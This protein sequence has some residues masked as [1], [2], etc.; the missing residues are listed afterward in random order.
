MSWFELLEAIPQSGKVTKVSPDGK[1]IS[2]QTAPGQSLELDLDKDPNIDVSQNGSKTSIKLNR[3][4]KNKLKKPGGV[5]AGGNVSIEEKDLKER[6]IGLLKAVAQQME[7][8]AHAG[9]YTAIE[10]L[11]QDVSEEELKGFLSDH[12]SPNEWPESVE[13]GQAQADRYHNETLGLLI[14]R[15]KS[16]I[17]GA[18]RSPVAPHQAL[19]PSH[20]KTTLEFVID[21]LEQIKLAFPNKFY[22]ESK[23]EVDNAGNIAGYLDTIDE[24][25]SMLFKGKELP[26]AHKNEIAYRIQ[27]AVDDIRTRELGLKPSN[28]RAQYANTESVKKKD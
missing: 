10:E 12:R 27:N 5:K 11:L 3:D 13:E 16:I 19:A 23:V 6:D 21:E 2:V 8:D 24:Y 28:I 20:F 9:D 14:K 26:L 17:D 15:L 22:K 1:K 25:I 7:A 18:T 4:N